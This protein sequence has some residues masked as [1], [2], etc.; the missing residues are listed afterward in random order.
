MSSTIELE[1]PP[2][3]LTVGFYGQ[4]WPVRMPTLQE[5]FG[6]IA[7][8]DAAATETIFIGFKR[9]FSD[10][11]GIGREALESIDGSII[12]GFIDVLGDALCDW[13]NATAALCKQWASTC[14]IAM[15]N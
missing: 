5:V 14:P 9:V 10:L 7:L 13:F 11:T 3:N 8:A 4:S 15:V 6:L 1:F 2:W 12:C